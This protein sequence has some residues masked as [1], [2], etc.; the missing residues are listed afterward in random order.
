MN[1]NPSTN[2]DVLAA[3]D[4]GDVN[5][6]TGLRGDWSDFTR[7]E[8]DERW[9]GHGYLGARR[10]FLAGLVESGLT[11]DQG[12]DRLDAADE[13]IH[14]A[15]AA[16]GLTYD[17]LFYWANAKPGRWYGDVLFGASPTAELLELF[18]S[19]DR[20]NLLPSV[21]LVRAIELSA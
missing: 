12:A 8:R 17:Q 4:A 20:F 2:P 9:L 11:V 14:N 19:A 1:P 18:E 7:M 10:S 3:I 16:E 21:E 5:P 13:F 6:K 15:A